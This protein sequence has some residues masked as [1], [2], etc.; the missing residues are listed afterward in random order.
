[1][2][3]PTAQVQVVDDLDADDCPREPGMISY[4]DRNC[5]MFMIC[6]CGCGREDFI[7]FKGYSKKNSL[8]RDYPEWKWNG[9]LEK[10][11]LH[12]SIVLNNRDGSEHWH[13]WLK[14]GVFGEESTSPEDCNCG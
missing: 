11:S 3:I 2:A 4:G 5:G 9:N 14:N 8:Q 6:P 12:P 1:M 7:S 10:P 13:G